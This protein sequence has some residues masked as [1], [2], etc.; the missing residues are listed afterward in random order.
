MMYLDAPP[1]VIESRVFSSMPAEFRKAG[2]RS[3]WADANKG[4]HP[5]D[6][7]IE[8][9][10]FDWDGHLYL[11]D[12]PFGRIFKVAP[13]GTWSLV[14]EYDGWPNGL[15]IAADGRILVADY[16]N[17]LMELDPVRGTI[18]PILGH[19]NSESFK[20]CNDLHIGPSGEIYFTDQGQTG[21]HDPTGRVFRLSPDGRLDRLI[22][23]GLSP[24]GLV[25]DPRSSVLF[26]AMTR[27]NS[28]WRVPLMRDGGVAKVGRFAS[29]FGTSGPDGLALDSKG[30]LFVAHASLGHV[31]V[32]APNGECIARIKSCAGPTCTNVALDEANHRLI[33]TES[34]TGSLLV[35]DWP[36]DS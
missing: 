5:V 34:S 14:I 16:M 25:L 1:R 4:G 18:R 35:A 26:V 11:V 22:A 30:H 29:F 24:N 13:D 36:G 23:N 15:K 28:I 19:C 27:D 17:G 7:F 21:L 31:F 2:V 32:L 9:P 12:I 6:S 20:G 8:G 10:C 3:A 33:V